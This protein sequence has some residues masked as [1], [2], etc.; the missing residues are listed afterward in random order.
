MVQNLI[1]I[2][3]SCFVLLEDDEGKYHISRRN[4][5]NYLAF[6]VSGKFFLV[7]YKYLLD[8]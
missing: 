1:G 4:M 7:K 3:F 5:I 6:I 8:H 2:I